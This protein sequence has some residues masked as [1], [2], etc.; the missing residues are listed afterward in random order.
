M[1]RGVE[2]LHIEAELT[3]PA[4]A[5]ALDAVGPE[6]RDL[7]GRPCRKGVSF[8]FKFSRSPDGRGF[9]YVPRLIREVVLFRPRDG[10][11]SGAGKL[12]M[13]SSPYDPLGDVPVL[14]LIDVGYGI[15]DNDM[16]P[17]RLVARV[18][19]PLGFAR[20]AMFKEDYVGWALDRGELP[21]PLKRRERAQRWKA[22]KEY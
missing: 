18:R 7:E 9:D 15:W 5:T 1:R 3:N 21:S 22:M 14:D 4:S 20:H 17:G 19:N 6:V 10:L 13:A 8:L 16:L 11:M 2:V 12:E